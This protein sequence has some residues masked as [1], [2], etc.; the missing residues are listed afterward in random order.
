MSAV[1]LATAYITVAASGS[2]LAP[3]FARSFRAVERVAGDSGKR[4]GRA[5]TGEVARATQQDVDKAKAAYEQAAK[6]VTA[7]VESQAVKVEN[8]R[9][10]EEIAQAKV[11]EALTK[12]GK[13][14]SQVLT[15]QDRLAM[16]SQKLQASQLEQ[17]SATE[18]AN[19]E[20]KEAKD[21]LGDAERAAD[22]AAKPF[23]T[24][25]DRVKSA[26]RGD[27]KGAFTRIERDGQGAANE[28]ERDFKKA[29]KD[30]ADGFSKSF[31]G[32][33]AG[34]AAGL[35]GYLGFDQLI[36]GSKVAVAEAM[37]LE[38]SIGG[39][40]TVF[41][42][43]AGQ[44][45][46][47]AD[48]ADSSLGMTANEYNEYASRLGASLKNAGTPMDELAGKT[49]GLITMGADL[50]SLYGGTTSEAV[51]ALSAALRGEMDPIERYGISLNDAAL[52][53]EGLALGIE[54][55][56]GAFTNQQKQLIVQSLLQKQS[57]DATG[58][59]AREQDTAA[60]VAQRLKARLTEVAGELGAKFLPWL[61]KAGNWML[62]KGIPAM[63]TFGEGIQSV[64]KVLTEGEFDGNLFGLEE[65]SGIVDFLFG[66][67]DAGLALW[68]KALKPLG[69]WIAK[70][71]EDFAAFFAGFGGTLIIAGISALV[72]AIVGLVSAISSTVLIIGAVVGA[73]TWFFTQT[74][75]GQAILRAVVDWIV[76]T[77]WPAIKAFGIAVADG[78]VWLWQN[79]LKPAWEGIRAA[80][81]ATVDWLVNSAWPFIQTVWD[82]IAAGATWLWRNVLEPVWTGIFSGEG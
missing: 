43:S 1:E 62:D 74:E 79:V 23:S 39:V 19:R 36:D 59:F 52:T 13:D 61:T 53:A 17:Q 29:G 27:F 50:A 9:R 81:A 25:G 40:N 54:K 2:D 37:N 58:N 33:F 49:N 70:N 24:L 5:L 38:Q 57:A 11:S 10:K 56:G 8:A 18:R 78:A 63:E 73:L 60:N 34:V 15:A 48:A 69:D 41:K 47:W 21:A 30:S 75:V 76:N 46:A 12:Y 67:R 77:A 80:I 4:M 3:S 64:W 51:D 71:W 22:R 32:G 45:H 20:L 44:M 72:G 42:D 65:D 16:S 14:S 82:G 6:R 28:L 7:T 66:L 55:T 68:E 26:M 31:R 35:G